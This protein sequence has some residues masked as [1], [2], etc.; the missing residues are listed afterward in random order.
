MPK[1]D[2]NLP[3]GEA[4]QKA[5]KKDK[6][7]PNGEALVDENDKLEIEDDDPEKIASDLEN[8]E[9]DKDRPLCEPSLRKGLKRLAQYK[10]WRH[11]GTVELCS[12]EEVG[13]G[14]SHLKAIPL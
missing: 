14:S 2:K 8:S 4:E 11:N 6:N 7:L 10:V 9:L 3:N 5:P 13:P 12:M 1:K